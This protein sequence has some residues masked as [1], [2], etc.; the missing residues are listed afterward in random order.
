MNTCCFDAA[1][2][3]SRNSANGHTSTV[4]NKLQYLQ[5]AFVQEIMF[6]MNTVETSVTKDKLNEN[7]NTKN[8]QYCTIQWAID[9]YYAVLRELCGTPS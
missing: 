7:S 2:G 9:W 4:C 6:V 1:V 8:I 5:S 3:R